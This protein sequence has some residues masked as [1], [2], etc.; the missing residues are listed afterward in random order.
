VFSFL[1]GSSDEFCNLNGI[2]RNGTCH[3]NR[4]W[5]IGNGNCS[6]LDRRP[7][8]SKQTAAIYGMSPNVTSWGGN[9][10]ADPD[11]GQVSLSFRCPNGVKPPMP[12]RQRLTWLCFVLVGYRRLHHLYVAEIS[13]PNDTQCGLASWGSHSTISHAV[14]TAGVS[15]PFVK[16]SVVVAQEGHNPQAILYKGTW[17]IF[18]I[19]NGSP[20][21]TPVSPCPGPP[22]PPC[23]TYVSTIATGGTEP[24][25]PQG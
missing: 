13:G 2:C 5:A 16:R 17:A 10:L 8:V 23:P 6:L 14:S 11:T 15:G 19:G 21:G 25:F 18:H 24:W 3:C 7:P 1:L 4:G 9:V 22:P 20:P 12:G